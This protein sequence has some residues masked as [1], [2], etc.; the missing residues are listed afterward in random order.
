[1]DGAGVVGCVLDGRDVEDGTVD[2]D[3]VVGARGFSGKAVASC[4]KEVAG[5]TSD[6]KSSVLE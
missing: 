5:R 6:R 2:V 3:N 1:V 4:A